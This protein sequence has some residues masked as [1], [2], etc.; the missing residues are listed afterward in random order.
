IYLDSHPDLYH[1]YEGDKYSHAC[2][3]RRIIEETDIKPSNIV[4]VGIRAPTPEQVE[5]ADDQ[6]IT[7]ISTREFQNKGA[8]EIGTEITNLFQQKVDFLYLS[9]DLDV[10]D[11][12]YA[13]G[14]GNPQPGGISTREII[15][16]IH[17]LS[18]L[19]LSA[20]DM[21]EFCP[22]YD[23]SNITAFVAAKLIQESLGVMK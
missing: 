19:P 9:I 1:D 6:G 16:L 8:A 17:G 14:L 21:V 4:Q 5:Y 15:D 13:P 3:V 11:P 12:A 22:K 10:L 2:V 18:D 20:I 7:I 23:Y